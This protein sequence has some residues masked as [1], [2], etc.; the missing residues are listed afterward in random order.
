MGQRAITGEE[1]IDCLLM[2]LAEQGAKFWVSESQHPD[3]PARGFRRIL[4]QMR[5]LNWLHVKMADGARGWFKLTYDDDGWNAVLDQSENMLPYVPR[6]AQMI[7]EKHYAET[8]EMVGKKT[9]GD[10]VQ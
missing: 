5:R 7:R 10:E 8:I 3:R 1:I 4:A 9:Q 2:E 6:T